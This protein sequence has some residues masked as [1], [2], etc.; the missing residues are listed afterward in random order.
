MNHKFK[1]IISELPRLK[2]NLMKC[3][4][5]KWGNFKNL[6]E[7]GIY[8]FFEKNKPI[9]VGRTKNFSGRLKQHGNKNSSRYSASLAFNL[10]K[11]SYNKNHVFTRGELEKDSEFIRAFD[12][13]KNRVRNMSYRVIEILD[14]ITQTI[15][16]VYCVLELKTHKYNSFDTH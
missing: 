10:A 1:N 13:A 14:P 16:E 6:S 9:Y 4:L 2:N 8:V 3:P 11:N 12:K 5:T 15:F 7:G